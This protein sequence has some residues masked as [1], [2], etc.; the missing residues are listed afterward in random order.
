[1]SS[2]KKTSVLPD[3]GAFSLL[4]GYTPEVLRDKIRGQEFLA[5]RTLLKR[6]R[7]PDEWTGPFLF[8]IHRDI[9]GRC[10]PT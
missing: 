3:E 5:T 7:G 6:R 8:G 2:P 10:F 4:P 1:M 9:F